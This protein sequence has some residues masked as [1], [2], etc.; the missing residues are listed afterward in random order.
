MCWDPAVADDN[1]AKKATS[2]ISFLG[3]DQT[4]SCGDEI[5]AARLYSSNSLGKLHTALF[6]IA[7]NNAPAIARCQGGN[8][9]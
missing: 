8:A 2:Q 1:V 9:R 5:M 4:S 3:S 7:Y 6:S